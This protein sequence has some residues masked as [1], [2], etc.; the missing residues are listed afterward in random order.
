VDGTI[1]PDLT[2]T[3][4]NANLPKLD[5][6]PIYLIKRPGESTKTMALLER[7]IIDNLGRVADAA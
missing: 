1:P 4:G 5:R 6:V 2:T 3:S 7:I